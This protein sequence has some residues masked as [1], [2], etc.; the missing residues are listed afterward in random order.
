MTLS[1]DIPTEIATIRQRASDDPSWAFERIR[2]IAGLVDQPAHVVALATILKSLEAAGLE[3]PHRRVAVMGECTV[4]A[5]ASALAL[6]LAAE[7]VV[8]QTFVA[9]F[10]TLRAQIYDPGS[11]LHAFA[12]Q[13]VLLA[14]S[15]EGAETG[16]ESDWQ[17]LWELLADRH[18]GLHIV[19]H[20][21]EMP[22][23]D[24][25]GPAEARA[26]WSHLHVTRQVNEAL[27]TASPGFVH[28]IDMERLAARVGKLSFRDP[29]L[30]HH[31][32]LPFAPKHV[33]DYSNYIAGA[34]RRAL[35]TSRKC[36]VL[37]LD[38]TLWSGIVGDD[39]LD[40]IRLG[41]G[42]A[43]GEAHAAFCTHVKALSKRGVIL[44]IASKNDPAVAMEVFEKHPHMPLKTTDFAA[45]RCNWDN[46]ADNLRSISAELNI[47]LSALVFVDD[48]PAECELVRRELPQVT[49]VE[50][51]IDPAR[52]VRE[53]DR[54]RLFELDTLTSEDI[55]RT[56]AY[57]ARRAAAD[58]RMSATNLE[59]YLDS[60]A[61]RGQ[62]WTARKCDLNRLAQMEGKTNQFN[63]TTMRWS[64]EQI[65]EFMN[66]ADHDVL[67]FRLADKFAD[68]GLVSSLVV[69]YGACV[70]ILSWLMSCRVFAR[71]SE[72]FI[73]ADL[74]ARAKARGGTHVLGRYTETAK[75]GVVADLYPKLGFARDGADF[76]LALKG[77]EAP[78]SFIAATDFT[79][80]GD[81]G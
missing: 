48:N 74:I 8:A 13:I 35:G 59:E 53:L 2:A 44:A 1:S 81:D 47:D 17:R 34:V 55:A 51:T 64:T 23:D 46:K 39:G 57:Q 38:N 41:P 58:V 43:L 9:P 19:Q 71:T 80:E 18:P 79:K 67:C 25:S 11:E 7:G 60:L 14:P 20:L 49:V 15:P 72:E 27:I 50:M 54:L 66:Q 56:R 76:V 16:I 42:D 10:G 30:W 65:V 62:V 40:G 32:K 73:F 37:D 24:F 29:R 12:P 68:H 33:P 3:H 5:L 63:L 21:Y 77:I 75:N 31:A 28:L 4:D 52:F 36:I 69:R 70:Q 22:E 6:A 45:I 26:E 61:M 78:P